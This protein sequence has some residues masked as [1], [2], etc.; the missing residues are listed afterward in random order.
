MS[1]KDTERHAADTT[2]E[3]TDEPDVEAHLQDTFDREDTAGERGLQDTADERHR[4]DE[5]L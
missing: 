4:L 3:S 2:D 1:E 5:S